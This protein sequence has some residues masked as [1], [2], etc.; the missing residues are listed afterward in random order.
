MRLSACTPFR[1]GS[2]MHTRGSSSKRARA[3]G[4]L[5]RPMR[6]PR[7]DPA[8]RVSHL[9][10]PVRS[11]TLPGSI[12]PTNRRCPWVVVCCVGT[13]PQTLQAGDQPTDVYSGRFDQQALDRRKRE[14]SRPSSECRRNASDRRAARSA[15]DPLLANSGLCAGRAEAW[16]AGNS[17]ISPWPAP[18]AALT[19]GP[20][21]R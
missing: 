14:S 6:A 17:S 5:R 4:T 9:G 8:G 1:L 21:R 15:R 7:D 3:I 19:P 20:G 2:A 18:C 13:W 12:V 11:L 10:C 16:L